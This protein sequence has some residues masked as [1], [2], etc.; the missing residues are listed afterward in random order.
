MTNSR[1]AHHLSLAVAGLDACL[2]YSDPRDIVF[3]VEE[4]NESCRAISRVTGE[5][6]VDD[7]LGAMSVVPLPL[8][9]GPEAHVVVGCRFS[10]FCIGK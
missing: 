1:Q 2:A 4:L 6:S 5:V 7:V 8:P 3:A 10:Q 9:L